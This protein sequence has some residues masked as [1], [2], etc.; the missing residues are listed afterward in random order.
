MLLRSAVLAL[1]LGALLA[2]VVFVLAVAGASIAL[3][4]IDPPVTALMLYRAATSDAVV[5][6][7]AHVPLERLPPRVKAMFVAV[8]DHAFYRHDGIDP[9]AIREAM[10]LNRELG[11]VTRGG[12][13][14]TMQ[15]AR[16]LFL[17]P[18]RTYLRKA[19]EALAAVTIELV[20]DKERILELYV[21][22]IEYGKGV[23]GIAAASRA[24]Y[25]KDASR[26]APD[27]ARRLVTI[28][29]SP[30]RYDVSSFARRRA[31]AERY[32][33]LLSMFP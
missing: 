1:A 13:T 18:N 22:T 15:L 4:V 14:I 25:G 12:S 31:L 11:R 21:N 6:P 7:I 9:A 33:T 29:A 32:R 28:V 24:H 26:L 5:R 2:P 20:L 8:E 19:L 16:T 3:S 27:E 17:T 30:L 23:Y 10:R